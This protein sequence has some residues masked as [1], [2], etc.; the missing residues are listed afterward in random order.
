[1]ALICSGAAPSEEDIAQLQ[2]ICSRGRIDVIAA[3]QRNNNNVE[4]VRLASFLSSPTPRGLSLFFH[5]PF[6]L[7]MGLACS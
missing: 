1:M 4:A 6:E 5:A 7:R 2:A 3:L